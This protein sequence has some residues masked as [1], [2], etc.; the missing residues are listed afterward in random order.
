MP[1]VNRFRHPSETFSSYDLNIRALRYPF[2]KAR[3]QFERRPPDSLVATFVKCDGCGD[4]TFGEAAC[5]SYPERTVS[6]E[7]ELLL[8]CA[9]PAH[10]LPATPATYQKRQGFETERAGE[11]RNYP[12]CGHEFKGTYSP[13]C[14]QEAD[15]AVHILSRLRQR[16]V[17]PPTVEPGPVRD[18]GRPLMR[19]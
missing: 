9:C 8:R 7:V 13:N 2:L 10:K 1:N 15:S 12:N 3:D 4:E 19:Q 11:L 5:S 18:S 17:R 6:R 14:S 16:M